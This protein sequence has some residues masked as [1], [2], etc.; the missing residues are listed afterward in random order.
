M[1]TLER[2]SGE[3]IVLAFAREHALGEHVAIVGPTGSGKSVLALTLLTERGKRLASDR[4]PTRIAILANKNRDK[5]MTKLGWPRLKR[6]DEWPPGY[7]K[8]Q[9][10][11]WPPY[12][13]AK[14]AP[15]RQKPVFEHVIVEASASGNQIIYVDEVAYFTEKPPEGLNMGPLMG[16]MLATGRSSGLSVFGATQRPR[17]VPVSLWTESTWLFAFRL[18]DREDIRRVADFGERETLFEVVPQLQKHEFLMIHQDTREA[19]IG[20]L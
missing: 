9:C 3:E 16:Q 20:K 11:V 10:V 15:G 1:P 13:D 4:R 7:A 2:A 19:V 8:E 14:Q 6:R 12:G 5:T 17:R 18:R